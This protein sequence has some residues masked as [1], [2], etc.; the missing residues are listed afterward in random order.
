[1]FSKDVVNFFNYIQIDYSK[2][3]GN[4][5]YIETGKTIN[6]YKTCQQRKH[7]KSILILASFTKSNFK[8]N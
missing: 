7:Y 8:V 1:M 2:Q 4:N 3:G 6:V 5:A